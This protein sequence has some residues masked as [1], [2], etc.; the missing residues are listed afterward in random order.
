MAAAL[1]R[2]NV[3]SLAGRGAEAVKD[4]IAATIAKLP[5]AAARVV[6]LGPR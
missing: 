5:E 4:A 2:G 6:D 1:S 3:P